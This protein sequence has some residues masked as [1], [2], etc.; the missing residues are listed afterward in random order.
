MINDG[1]NRIDRYY[2][3]PLIVAHRGA[4]VWEKENSLQAFSKAIEIG[5]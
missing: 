1:D 5:M 2:R 3:W 4:S